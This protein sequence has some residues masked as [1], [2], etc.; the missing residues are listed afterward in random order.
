MTLA[1]ARY[2]LA[3]RHYY[4]YETILYAMD[5]LEAAGEL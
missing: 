2:V 1:E 4:T 5:I 3:H